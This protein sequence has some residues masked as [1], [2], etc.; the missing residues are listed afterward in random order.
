MRKTCYAAVV[1]TI[2]FLAGCAHYGALEDDFGK[3]YDMAKYGQTLNPGASKNLEPVT[4]LNGEASEANMDKYIE[5]FGKTS[6]KPAT[7]GFVVMPADT[8]GM[9][10]DAYGK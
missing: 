5:S 6:K 3:S 2:L 7:K 4:G 1:L 9:G 10:Q 8:T